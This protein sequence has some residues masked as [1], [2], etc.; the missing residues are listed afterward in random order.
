MRVL[1]F[2][3]HFGVDVLYTHTHTRNNVNTYGLGEME[4]AANATTNVYNII[5][6]VSMTT[7]ARDSE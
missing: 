7:P 6:H 5:I 1:F 2:F 4:L 3:K